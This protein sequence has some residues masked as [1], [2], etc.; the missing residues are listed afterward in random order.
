M[1]DSVV[2]VFY[3]LMIFS[4]LVLSVPE[5]GMWESSNIIMG[6][7]YVSISFN[8]ISWHV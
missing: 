8:Y 4:L 1:A 7:V 2:Q 6:Y 3:I 5:R